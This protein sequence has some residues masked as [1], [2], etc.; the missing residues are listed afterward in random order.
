V[1]TSEREKPAPEKVVSPPVESTETEFENV[2][3]REIGRTQLNSLLENIFA[4][5]L[6]NRATEIHFM[7]LGPRRTD[8]LFRLDG[9]LSLWVSMEDVRCEAVPTAL[10]MLS[11]NM[12]RY[13]RMTA[14]QDDIQA[15]GRCRCA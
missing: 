3:D 4:D 14:Q 13:E 12:D 6:R 1:L 11:N 7:P 8:V 2:M 10:K 5:A 15:G 9:H